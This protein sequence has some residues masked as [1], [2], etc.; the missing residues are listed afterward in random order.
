ME[1]TVTARYPYPYCHVYFALNPSLTPR[2]LHA[3]AKPALLPMPATYS[4]PLLLPN[5][6]ISI[7]SSVCFVTFG[8]IHNLPGQTFASL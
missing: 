5:E 8:L 6:I 3:R 7:L 1:W 2:L 4:E